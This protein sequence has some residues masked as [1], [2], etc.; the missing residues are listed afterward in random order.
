MTQRKRRRR[1]KGVR[2]QLPPPT[3]CR[4]CGSPVVFCENKEIY[5]RN[6]GR[7]PYAYR[8]TKC[9]ARVGVHPNTNVPLGT[10]ADGRTRRARMVSKELFYELCELRGFS[11]GQGYHMLASELGIPQRECHFGWFDGDRCDQA[12]QI[13]E[14]QLAHHRPTIFDSPK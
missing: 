1:K 2:D 4:Y 13:L 7:W 5:G 11:R 14:A 12:K 3:E 6:Y 10:L 8:C 9:D